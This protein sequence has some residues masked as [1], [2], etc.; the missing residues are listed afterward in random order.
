M[1]SG[2]G[3]NTSGGIPRLT[4]FLQGFAWE[5]LRRRF[6]TSLLILAVILLSFSTASAASWSRGTQG[7]CSGSQPKGDSWVNWSGYS[8][9]DWGWSAHN[10]YWW[11]G[12]SWS[13]Q[14]YADSGTVWGSSGTALAHSSAGYRAGSW[15]V[16]ASHD[17]SFM[18]YLDDRYNFTC[19]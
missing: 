10:L 12:S 6:L 17:G 4:M 8:P 9:W 11:N 14:A 3:L 7:D 15:Q 1:P 19:A 2:N 18:P 13:Q 16:A 5:C